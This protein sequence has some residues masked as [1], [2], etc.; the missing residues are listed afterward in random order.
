MVNFLINKFDSWLLT[1]DPHRRKTTT[2]IPSFLGIA[3]FGIVGLILASYAPIISDFFILQI[4]IPLIIFVITI[5]IG[6][7]M[8]I[9]EKFNKLSLRQFGILSLLGVFFF[10]T[11][12]WSLVCYSQT[13]GSA[14]MASFPILLISFHGHLYHSKIT[15][16]FPLLVSLSAMLV[17]LL[18]IQSNEHYAII[19]IAGI[20][21]LFSHLLLGNYALHS[22]NN[23]KKQMAL[24]E[25]CDAQLLAERTFAL[26]NI[27]NILLELRSYNH[28][29]NNSL[30]GLQI[31]LPQFISM[32]NKDFL[33][34]EDLIEI[35]HIA[36]LLGKNLKN[37][38][39]VLSEARE[40]GIKS[41][42]DAIQ[43]FPTKIYL[44]I[45]HE[46]KTCYSDIVFNFL[47][48]INNKHINFFGGQVT[49][50]RIISNLI[51]N[52]IQGDGKNGATTINSTLSYSKDKK[53]INIEIID[54]GPGFPSQIINEP[55]NFGY[56]TKK[57]G[58]G[59]GLYTCKKLIAANNGKINFE[60]INPCGAKIIIQLPSNE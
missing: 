26:K 22:F 9:L 31:V 56:T 43:I 37:L 46:F 23:Q 1:L 36:R 58:S 6:I 57:D 20:M 47:P 18:C 55:F 10:Q 32:V 41:N 27:N 24:K 5:I 8:G 7:T 12:M 49:F 11:F 17:S 59:L 15:L 50:N 3:I 38:N 21:S 14:V 39:T 2:T 13:E 25:A 53:L 45:I 60:N 30:S 44:D 16:P 52:A 35:S 40:A 54:N 29:A 19:S 4:K 28:D 33:S 51:L 34:H 42:P 48:E